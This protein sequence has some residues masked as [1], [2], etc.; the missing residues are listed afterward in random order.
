MGAEQ[1]DR[2]IG[3]KDVTGISQ[4]NLR[5]VSQLSLELTNVLQAVPLLQEAGGWLGKESKCQ[6]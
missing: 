6:D 3:I 2:R 1:F 5:L 4:N